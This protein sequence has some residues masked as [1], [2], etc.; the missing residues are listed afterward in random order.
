MGCTYPVQ[1]KATANI[2]Y[3]KLGGG[4]GMG[5]KAVKSGRAVAG[6]ELQEKSFHCHAVVI[7]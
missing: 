3:K 7:V 2:L 1:R 4:G 5:G 6:T